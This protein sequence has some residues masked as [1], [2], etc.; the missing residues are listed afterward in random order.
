VMHSDALLCG[1]F[2]CSLLPFRAMLESRAQLVAQRVR[3]ARAAGG[4]A[5]ADE[6]GLITRTE[7][8]G[9]RSISWQNG[10]GRPYHPR[11]PRRSVYRCALHFW[12]CKSACHPLNSKF[13]E[14]FNALLSP[15]RS[16]IWARTETV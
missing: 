10:P 4:N 16:K 11:A 1:I 8:E 14:P 3:E 15:L 9:L 5:A 7:A 6:D 2:A 12:V 13:K